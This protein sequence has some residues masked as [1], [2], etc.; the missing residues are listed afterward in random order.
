M[1]EAVHGFTRVDEEASPGAWV[2][3]LDRLHAEPFYRE[4]KDRVRAILAP[5]P[6]GQYL[7]IGAGVGTDARK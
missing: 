6:T 4:Y 3:C 7:E 2:K 5:R 1:S